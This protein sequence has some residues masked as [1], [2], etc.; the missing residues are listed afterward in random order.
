MKTIAVSGTTGF[1]GK[2]FL[3]YNKDRFRIIAIDLRKLNMDELPL[4]GVDSIILLSRSGTQLVLLKS[5]EICGYFYLR[6]SA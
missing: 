3:E 5:A 2:R 6:R 4:T 1:V